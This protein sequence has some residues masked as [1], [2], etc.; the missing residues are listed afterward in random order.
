MICGPRLTI[1]GLSGDSGKTVVSVGLCRFWQKKGHKV[2]PFKKGPDYIDMGWL[3]LGASYPCYN[4]DLFLMNKDQALFS[5]EIHAKHADIALIEGNRGLYD[6]LDVEGSVS[7]AELAKLLK[8]P[9]IIIADCTKVTRTVAAIILGCQKLDPDVEIK[10]VI[11]NR[12]ANSR[13]ENLIRK[14][15][16]RYCRLPVV[17]AIPKITNITFPGRHLGLVPPQEHPKAQEAIT[18]ATEIVEKY[19]DMEKLWE[20]A[21]EVQPLLVNS[22]QSLKES[23]VNSYSS[24]VKPGDQCPMTKVQ[25]NDR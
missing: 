2:I 7:T 1:T 5:F 19:L 24:F 21:K 8:S 6:G 22:P 23:L 14:S 17:G 15:I 25:K 16:E 10:G 4:L 18:K 12:L 20:I 11:L 9:V 3:S 13:Q